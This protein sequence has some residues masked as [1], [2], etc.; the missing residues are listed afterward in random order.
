M[1]R[2][3]DERYVRL[4]TRD[5]IGWKMLPWQARCVLPLLMRVLDRAGLIDLGE[6]GTEGLAAILDLP[7]EVVEPGLGALLKR[8]TLRMSGSFLLMPN[9]LEA[10][11]AKAS[12]AQRQRESRGR[13]RDLA[14]AVE[15]GVLVPAIP[16]NQSRIVTDGH[17]SGQEVTGGHAESR[18][19]TPS[20]AVPSRAVPKKTSSA[21]AVAPPKTSDLPI[22]AIAF[23]AWTQDAKLERFPNAMPEHPGKFITAAWWAMFVAAVPDPERRKGTWLAFLGS[24]YPATLRPAFSLQVFVAGEEFKKYVPDQLEPASAASS[25]P[26]TAAGALWGHILEQLDGAGYRYAAG[27]LQ[28]LRPVEADDDTL[29]LEARD[30]FEAEGVE[31]NYGAQLRTLAAELGLAVRIRARDDAPTTGRITASSPSPRVARA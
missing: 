27:Q 29:T 30:G 19:V 2:W 14:K 15:A 13:A 10:Q 9:F 3:E 22:E 23:G 28:S 1:L 16:D 4:Y 24:A 6:Y 11:E 20:C 17:E 7:E 18:V 8:G 21:A 26:D 12:D 31:A 5:T 25:Q